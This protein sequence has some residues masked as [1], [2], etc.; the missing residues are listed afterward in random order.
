M[1][2]QKT[3]KAQTTTKKQMENTNTQNDFKRTTANNCKL[4]RNET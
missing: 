4:I 1:G 2:L 3:T